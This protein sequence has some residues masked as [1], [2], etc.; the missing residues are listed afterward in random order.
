MRRLLYS[1]VLVLLM[2]GV[3][4]SALSAAEGDTESILVAQGADTSAFPEIAL[5]VTLP[6]NM[7][8]GSE[9][10]VLLT[11][12][13][14]GETIEPMSVEPLAAVRAPIDVVLLMDTSGS[15]WGMP[16]ADARQA[17]TA[18]VAAMGPE[19]EIAVVSFGTTVEVLS[20][21]TADRIA[22]RRAVESL[23]AEGRTALYDGV[24]R[25]AELLIA[26]G[27]R[28]RVV[29]LLSDGGDNASVNSI[30]YAV[31]R[32]R[33][34]RAPMY[35]IALETPETDLDAL[36]SMAAQSRGRLVAVSDS[37]D[38][39]RL[40]EDIAR[41]LTTQ[42]RVTYRSAEPNTKDL[43][44]Q[45]IAEV[46]GRRGSALFVIDNPYFYEAQG[47]GLGT[48]PA[49]PAASFALASSVV[50]LAFAAVALGTGALF[51]M[52]GRRSSRI[53]ELEFYDQ[54]RGVDDKT[55]TRVAGTTG[56]IRDAVEAVAGRRGLTPMVHQKLE[57]AGL[58]LRPVEYM[59]LHLVGV[60]LFGVVAVLLTRSF[61][62]SLLV[63]VV[64]VVL[65]IA[66][67][68]NTIGRRKHAFEDQL[69]EILSMMASSLRAGWGI[70]QSIDLVVQEMSD[71]AA[72]EFRRVQAE[73]RLG[74]SVEEALEKMA[75]RLDSDDFRWTVTAI[76]IQREVGGN[77]AEVLDLVAGTMRERAELR[78]HIRALTSEGR[79]S[80]VILLLLPFVML[81]L[82][83]IV[84]PGY[85]TLMFSTG[86]GLVLLVIGAVLLVIGGIWLRRASEVEI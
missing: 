70:G 49:S 43:E 79:L 76:A 80:A 45:V 6:V 9:G 14:N 62:L 19:D 39:E 81:A 26:R 1:A 71:P 57:R 65:P 30:D 8:A 23:E 78:R 47:E 27:E 48:E 72:G 82:L 74:L 42:Y 17:A 34:S 28:D 67:L 64:A 60:V 54:L 15:M 68:E 38:L 7:L 53:D 40:Y 56:V 66:L 21:F 75:N 12:R 77:L 44:L 37:G 31:E 22:L 2:L 25:S 52:F 20:D 3:T 59:Y 36:A 16:M 83:L 50:A 58:P 5:T 41:E 35:A 29:V 18:F 10:D 86:M 13:E 55:T 32:L 51:G 4:A 61:P 84:N 24:A 69:P 73:A 46:N 63:V 11:V 33:A 85:M